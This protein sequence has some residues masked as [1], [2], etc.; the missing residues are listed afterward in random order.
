MTGGGAVRASVLAVVLLGL[1]AVAGGASA[2]ELAKKLTGTWSG[3]VIDD[4]GTKTPV[5][6]RLTAKGGDIRG[7]AVGAAG[8]KPVVI[9]GGYDA[10]EVTWNT[11]TGIEYDMKLREVGGKPVLKGTVNGAREGRVELGRAAQ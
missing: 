1:A 11:S 5:T 2:D 6:F 3:Q 4:A 9:D 7:E 10:T 8:A